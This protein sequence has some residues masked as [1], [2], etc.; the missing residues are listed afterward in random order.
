ELEKQLATKSKALDELKESLAF[1]GS[2]EQS[3]EAL[4]LRISELCERVD[5][6]GS[7]VA[8][9]TTSMEEVTEQWRVYDEVY[10]AVNLKTIR[11]L[12]CV[13]QCK[14]SVLSLEALKKQI[15]TLQ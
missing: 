5:S 1:S 8:Q 15:K 10:A 7:Q 4:S 14:P 2:A 12:Y 13:N 6:I 11:Y 9:L 3:P